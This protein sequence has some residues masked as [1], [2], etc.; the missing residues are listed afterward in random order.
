MPSIAGLPTALQRE[1]PRD[2]AFEQPRR[3][4][5]LMSVLSRGI[6]RG[7]KARNS[8]SARPS[9]QSKTVDARFF[10]VE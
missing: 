8:T 10:E 1:K 7:S 3:L 9:S 2:C 6:G 5:L 4:S